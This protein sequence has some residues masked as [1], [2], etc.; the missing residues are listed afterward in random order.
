M[1]RAAMT[2]SRAIAEAG[3]AATGRWTAGKSCQAGS[4]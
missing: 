3:A 1:T 4:K 2:R